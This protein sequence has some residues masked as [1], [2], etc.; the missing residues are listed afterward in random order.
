MIVCDLT[1]TMTALRGWH[2]CPLDMI[3]SISVHFFYS[4]A[5]KGT[6]GSFCTV[7]ALEPAIS[8]SNSGPFYQKTT[9]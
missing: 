2:T 7:L 6:P 9:I 3:P 4:L 1:V 8:P 5:E